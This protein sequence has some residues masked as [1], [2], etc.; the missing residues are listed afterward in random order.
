MPT[1]HD[2]GTGRA[3]QY[4]DRVRWQFAKTMPQWPHEYTVK[5]WNEDI[6]AEFEAFV[7]LISRNGVVKPW[8]ANSDSP[9]YHHK[10]LEIDGW[11]YWYMDDDLAEVTLVNRARLD[12]DGLA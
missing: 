5:R 8:P 7:A 9:R 11:E 3:R 6:A 10:Y 2:F 12:L 4:I 1:L